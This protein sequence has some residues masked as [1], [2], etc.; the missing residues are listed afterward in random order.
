LWSNQQQFAPSGP[1]PTQQAYAQWPIRERPS[2][3][4]DDLSVRARPGQLRSKHSPR[5]VRAWFLRALV[6]AEK[7]ARTFRN[8]ESCS[9]VVQ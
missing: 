4:T 8:E 5:L 1:A 6:G 9:V 7:P 2:S 3:P